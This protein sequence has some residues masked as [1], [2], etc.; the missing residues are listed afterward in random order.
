MWT[1]VVQAPCFDSFP[2]FATAVTSIMCSPGENT[3]RLLAP[4]IV[5]ESLAPFGA[6]IVKSRIRFPVSVT[7]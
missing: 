5:R 6:R 3:S 2:S 1:M 7:L 4:R